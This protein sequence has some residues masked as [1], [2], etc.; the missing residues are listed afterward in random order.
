MKPV[1]RKAK[2]RKK[3]KQLTIGDQ[4][5]QKSK[6]YMESDSEGRRLNAT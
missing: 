5:I 4:K 1:K 2:E 6:G 3:K